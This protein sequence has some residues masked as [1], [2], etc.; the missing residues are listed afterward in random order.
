MNGAR[1]VLPGETI[2]LVGGGQLGRMFALEARRMGYRTVVLDPAADAPAAVVAD[3]SIAAPLDDTAAMAELARRSSVITLEWE[4]ADVGAL[5]EL[6]RVVPVHPGPAVLEVAQHRV[7]EK[8]AARRLGVATTDFR[9]LRT[10]AELHAALAEVG[11]PA[12]LKTATGG[13]DGKGQAVI[14]DDSFADAAFDALGGGEA[15]LILEGWVPF[16]REISV[17]CA[18]ST[19]GEV[20][21]FPV[22]ENIHRRGILHC[23]TVPAAVDDELAQRARGVAIALCE[24][25]GVV[26]LLAVE[27]FVTASGQ[28]LMNEIAPRPHNSGHFTWEACATSQ[29]EQQLRAVCGLPLGSTELLR[30]AAMINLMGEDVGTGLDQPAAAAALAVPGVSLHLYGK[31]EARTGRKMGHLTALAG[32]AEQALERATH[33]WRAYTREG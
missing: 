22:A 16:V 29:F 13:Y 27:M 15:E 5:R 12:I 31:R 33:A 1:Q 21:A 18:R 11:A 6:E 3:E 25:L 19:A 8:D 28:V 10:R 24:G 30:P 32:S 20:A 4:N 9:A 7:R 17:V 2:G 23:T 14:R 26:G